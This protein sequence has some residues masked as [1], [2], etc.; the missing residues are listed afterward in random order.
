MS[1]TCPYPSEDCDVG[2]CP[3]H[4]GGAPMSAEREQ[5]VAVCFQ[6]YEAERHLRGVLS[7]RRSGSGDPRAVIGACEAYL[8]AWGISTIMQPAAYLNGRGARF[9]PE[10]DDTGRWTR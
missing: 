6:R 8:H 5:A 9:A 4:K 10:T 2:G 1:W 3:T 7:E